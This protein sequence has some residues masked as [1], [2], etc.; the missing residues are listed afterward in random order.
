[1]NRAQAVENQ[2]ETNKNTLFLSSE[3]KTAKEVQEIFTT[4]INPSKDKVNI[5]KLK[6]TQNILIVELDSDK[7]MEKLTQLPKLRDVNLKM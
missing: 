5:K 4:S 1:M 3:G 2:R 6:T 7:D